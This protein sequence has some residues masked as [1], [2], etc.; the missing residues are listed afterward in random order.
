MDINVVFALLIIFAVIS[1]LRAR[2]MGHRY[3]R[4]Q[5]EIAQ[6]RAERADLQPQP[7]GPTADQVRTLEDRVRVLER[8]VT[9]RGHD[10]AHQIE[11]LR[12][13]P[14]ERQLEQRSEAK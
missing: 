13:R 2:G 9:D 6:L 7:R 11:A 1:V 12:D 10:I 3:R 5:G 4:V 14:V 8:I